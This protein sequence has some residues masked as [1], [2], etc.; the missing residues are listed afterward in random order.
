MNYTK[1]AILSLIWVAWVMANTAMA[2]EEQKP[3]VK[4]YRLYPDF[5]TNLKQNGNPHYI[6]IR[7]EVMV[8]GDE[9]VELVK[10]NEP[11]LQDRL[12]T[13][14]HGMTKNEVMSYEGKKALHDEALKIVQAALTEETGKPLAKRILFTKMV[15]E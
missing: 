6:Q 2:E 3:T 13:L 15:V 12:L 1:L 11:L 4:Y 7:V 5:L 10:Y 14:F 8:E 9:Q